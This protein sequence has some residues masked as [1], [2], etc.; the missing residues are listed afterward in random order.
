MHAQSTNNNPGICRIHGLK[1]NSYSCSS[2]Y[3]IQLDLS[4]Y[5]RCILDKI[6][7]NPRLLFVYYANFY[8]LPF[9]VGLTLDR[10]SNGILHAGVGSI[11]HDSVLFKSFKVFCYSLSED[12]C[13]WGYMANVSIYV[14]AKRKLAN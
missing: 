13:K 3:S 9:S 4:W 11:V 12:A 7:L 10:P 14:L 6:A 5:Y 8:L 2:P 1:L